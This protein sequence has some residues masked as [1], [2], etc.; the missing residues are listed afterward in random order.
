MDCARRPAGRLALGGGAH[1]SDSMALLNDPQTWLSFV[2]LSLLEVVLGIDNVIFLVILVD[3]LPKSQRGRGRI[4]GLCFAM[5]TRIGLLFSVTWIATMRSPLLAVAGRDITGRD[6]I[7]FAGGVFLI[8]QS[9]LEIRD[10]LRGGDETHT[11]GLVKGFWLVIAQA[12]LIDILFSLDSVFTAV[13]L[14]RQIEVM[15]AAI[16]ASMLV[17][18]VVASAV[19]A[20]IDRYPTVKTLALAFLVIIGGALIAESL[21]L[22]FPKGYLYFALGFSAAVEW[23]NILLRRRLPK[24]A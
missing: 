10:M 6:L 13:G 21:D 19:G 12:G 23:I 2:M 8:V 4:L 20:F 1:Y 11:P 17:M 16:V 5:L 15:V 3:R 24:R 14:A 7:L 9:I 18:M 22:E